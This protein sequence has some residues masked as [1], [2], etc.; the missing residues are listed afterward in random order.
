VPKPIESY[1]R[2]VLARNNREQKLLAAQRHGWEARK[3]YPGNNEWR[4]KTT[5]AAIVWEATVKKAVE[6][7]G[8]DPGVRPLPHFDTMS[9]IFDDAVLLRFKKADLMLRSSNV[10][11]TLAELYHDH[12]SDLFGQAGLQRV[13][14]CYVLN[15]F[16]TDIVWAGAVA[17][18]NRAHLWHFEFAASVMESKILPFPERPKG[19]TADLAKPRKAE[20]NPKSKEESYDG[21]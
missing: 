7:L 2:Q 13:E 6:S 8:D 11:T 5:R 4:R 20:K 15:R 1:V 18:E 19:S 3:T 14:A 17:R 10:Q 21:E 12:D 9:F 16:E